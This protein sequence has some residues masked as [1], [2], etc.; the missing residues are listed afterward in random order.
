MAKDYLTYTNHLGEQLVFGENNL[1]IEESDLPNWQYNY[2]SKNG[3][4]TNFF[5]DVTEHSIPAVI[6]ADTEEEGNAIRDEVYSIIKADI[7]AGIKGTLIYKGWK[8]K[9]FITA[10][11][12]S[13]W[14]EYAAF[15]DIELTVTTD[16]PQWTKTELFSFEANEGSIEPYGAIVGYPYT[17]P[18]QYA[19]E[20][21]A[22]YVLTN[23]NVGRSDFI[24]TI[25]GYVENPEIMIGTNKYKL[26]FTIP[27]HCKAEI[28]TRQKTI[29][30][31]SE[32]GTAS[33]IFQFKSND[34]YIFEQIDTGTQQVF[35]DETFS[36]D[37]EL[38]EVRSEPKWN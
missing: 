24:L 32:R 17:Y 34:S 13:N 9:C 25:Y 14:L 33:D 6:M 12:H 30:L 8:L 10:E 11:T 7:E 4:I 35:W 23:E 3:K 29:K 38:I 36:F 31:I 18:R 27:K 28:N 1:F 16:E 15:G 26:N 22:F 19:L 5:Q 20:K 2:N 37:V 21:R